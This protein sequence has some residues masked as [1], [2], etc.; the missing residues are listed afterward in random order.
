MFS[1]GLFTA[2]IGLAIAIGY[3]SGALAV[4]LGRE[5]SPTA[6]ILS[7]ALAMSLYARTLLADFHGEHQ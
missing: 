2:K 4:E 6:G 5:V 7:F 1:S 3:L